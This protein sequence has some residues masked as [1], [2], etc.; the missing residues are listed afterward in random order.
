MTTTADPA[1]TPAD[2]SPSDYAELWRAIG[3]LEGT[4]N[5]L[6]TGQRELRD[7]Q[8]QLRAEIQSS[9]Q[10]LRAEIQAGLREVNPWVDRLFY[11]ILAFGGAM[12]VA[13]FAS[14]F[15]GG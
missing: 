1:P 5:S 10:Q 8:E 12:I 15:V 9:Q 13:V 14:R 6:V 11:T 4:L 3:R 7:G 2:P